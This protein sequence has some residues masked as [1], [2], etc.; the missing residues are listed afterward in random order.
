MALLR[1]VTRTGVGV[2]MVEHRL[3]VTMPRVDRTVL[4]DGGRI[5]ED[6]LRGQAPLRAV[7]LAGPARTDLTERLGPEPWRARVTDVGAPD[8]PPSRPRTDRLIHLECVSAG[9]SRTGAVLHGVDLD[10]ARGERVAVLGANGAGKS[11]LLAL[12]AGRIQPSTGTLRRPPRV[13]EVPQNPDLVLYCETVAAE[14]AYGPAAW[15]L[16]DVAT[17]VRVCAEALSVDT[18]LERPPQSLSRGQRLRVAVASMVSCGATVLAL[19]EPTSGQDREQVERMFTGLAAALPDALL[20]F[21]THD[22]DVALRHAT[23]ILVLDQGRLVADIPARVDAL[24]PALTGLPVLL[25][26]LAVLCLRLGVAY[27][28]VEEVAAQLVPEASGGPA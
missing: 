9:W 21:A 22:V 13:H 23:R 24:A 5:V 19:D 2:L 12:I 17:R 6:P 20:L 14:L 15:G 7:G 1:A 10:L 11:T 27:G 8:L 3:E 28:T 18:L 4:M 25:P 26:P 16:P